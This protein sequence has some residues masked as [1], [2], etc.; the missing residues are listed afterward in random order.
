M[1]VFSCL[2]LHASHKINALFSAETDA[3][4]TEATGAGLATATAGSA[5]FFTITAKDSSGSARQTGGD[6]FVVELSGELSTCRPRKQRLLT[7]AL[8]FR[9]K[10]HSSDADGSP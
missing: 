1:Q 5:A 6:I 10:R 9:C 7:A 8:P 4:Q 3:Q 2:F